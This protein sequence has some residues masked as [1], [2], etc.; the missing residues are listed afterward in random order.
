MKRLSG[1]LERVGGPLIETFVEMAGDVD[2]GPDTGVTQPR[3]DDR[4]VSLRLVP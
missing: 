1:R 3:G 2:D 4:R